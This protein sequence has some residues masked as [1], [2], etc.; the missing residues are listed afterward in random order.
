MKKIAVLLFMTSLVICGGLVL[1]QYQGFSKDVDAGVA[2]FSYSQEIE[3]LYSD[4]ALEVRQTFIGLPNQPID[5]AWSKQANDAACHVETTASCER[6]NDDATS[7]LAGEATEQTITYTIPLAHG[8]PNQLL[9]ENIFTQLPTGEVISSVVHMSSSTTKKGQWVTGLP[10]AS[11]NTLNGISYTVYSG[12]GNVYD[13]FWQAG[14][15]SLKASNEELSIYTAYNV[16]EKF[17][18]ELSQMNMSFDEHVAIIQAEA[19]PTNDK[20][21]FIFMPKLNLAEVKKQIVATQVAQLFTFNDTP[22]WLQQILIAEVGDT[23]ITEPR[24]QQVVEV[25]HG[26]LTKEQQQKFSKRL[27]DLQGKD[28]SPAILDGILSDILGEKTT[29]FTRNATSDTLFPLVIE[30]TRGVY[31]NE[32]RI[33]ELV[34]LTYKNQIYY[35]A[36]ALL[37]ALGYKAE[38]GDNGYYVN[39]H[40]AAYRF[41]VTQLFYVYNDRRYDTKSRPVD[42]IG[43]QYYIEEAWLVRLFN[44]DLR[45][46]DR[47]IE[48]TTIQE[49][50]RVAK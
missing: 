36:T 10:L 13:L 6:L 34:A 18:D 14:D 46:K 48:I 49:P 32:I 28:V 1:F 7:F 42:K 3:V 43:G 22:Q 45:K 50:Q 47:V 4:K 16:T 39:N 19:T 24:G 26:Y 20:S 29:F 31:V 11:T 41:P 25:L 40:E 35:P 21:R 15:F 44:V 17:M 9:L 5:I 12:Y 38:V 33:D 2:P 30:D 8:L 27:K 23:P 37:S